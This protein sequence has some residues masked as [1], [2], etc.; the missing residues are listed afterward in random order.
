MAPIQVCSWSTSFCTQN[1]VIVIHDQ[2]RQPVLQTRN[3]TLGSINGEEGKERK[4]T[5][6]VVIVLAGSAI[7]T[8]MTIVLAVQLF[9]WTLER[10][11]ALQPFPGF[12]PTHA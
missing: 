11:L 2:A 12:S 1:N 7:P 10:V 3:T 5:M 6:I 8:K 9:Q 4:Y